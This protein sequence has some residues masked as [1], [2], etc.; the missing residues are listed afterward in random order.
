MI[1]GQC[2]CG[3]VAF[4]LDPEKVGLFNRCYCKKCQKNSGSDYVS[5]LQVHRDGFTWVRGERRLRSYESSPGVRRAFCG[6]CG[7]RLPM[8]DVPGDFVPVPTGT[9]NQDPGLNP[10]VNMHLDARA[11]WSLVDEHIHCLQDHGTSEFWAE[12]S[13]KK[14]RDA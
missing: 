9:L 4:K 5:Q 13:A 14:G 6:N 11:R 12:F 3:E 8:T 2:L 7:S 1:E 10:E